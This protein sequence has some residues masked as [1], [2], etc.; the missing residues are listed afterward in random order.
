MIE[1]LQWL[2][3]IAVLAALTLGMIATIAV[4]LSYDA[5]WLKLPHGHFY[6]GLDTEPTSAGRYFYLGLGWWGLGILPYELAASMPPDGADPCNC[7]GA[8]ELPPEQH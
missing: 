7:H 8:C 4:A 1:A 5:Y 6:L 3:A 2:A